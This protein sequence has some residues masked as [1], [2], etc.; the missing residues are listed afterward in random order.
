MSDFGKSGPLVEISF[1]PQSFSALRIQ[2][3]GHTFREEV[4]SVRST[5]IRLHCRLLDR[6]SSFSRPVVLQGMRTDQYRGF[7]EKRAYT[8]ALY[9][10]FIRCLQWQFSKF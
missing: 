10:F 1:S 9:C 7:T 4:L 6:W 2:D 5:K 8:V 3:N